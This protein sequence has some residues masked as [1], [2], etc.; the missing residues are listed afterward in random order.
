MGPIN[1][2]NLDLLCTLS[3][4]TAHTGGIFHVSLLVTHF[5]VSCVFLDPFSV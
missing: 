1:T 3:K 2:I 4:S 5:L